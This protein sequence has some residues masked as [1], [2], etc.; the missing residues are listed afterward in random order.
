MKPRTI[1]C[2]LCFLHVGG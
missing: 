1:G 2:S